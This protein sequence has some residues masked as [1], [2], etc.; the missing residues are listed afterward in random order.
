LYAA[1]RPASST[2]SGVTGIHNTPE[3]SGARCSANCARRTSVLQPAQ[4]YRHRAFF[5]KLTRASL[6]RSPSASGHSPEPPGSTGTPP[7]APE[8][9]RA[10]TGGPFYA[11]GP[12]GAHLHDLRLAGTT[13]VVHRCEVFATECLRA[14]TGTPGFHQGLFGDPMKQTVPNSPFR[15]DSIVSLQRTT[16]LQDTRQT[17]Q[18]LWRHGGHFRVGPRLSSL[19]STLNEPDP[20]HRTSASSA[21]STSD[22]FCPLD[23]G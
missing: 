11:A 1:G 6:G 23:C 18:R 7:G 3:P 8:R 22:I 10:L 14:L 17:V 13:S 2:P 20:R 15:G 4:E 5:G 9:P 12:F 16:R 19:L 21:L